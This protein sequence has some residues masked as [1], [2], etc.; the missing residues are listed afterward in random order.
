MSGKS[1]IIISP[2]GSFS[3]ESEMINQLFDA[4]VYRYHIHKIEATEQSIAEILE[5]VEPKYLSRITLHSHFHLVLAYGVGGIH[6]SLAHR[7]SLGNDY[8]SKVNLY[9]SF[10]VKVSADLGQE[11]CYPAD[12]AISTEPPATREKNNTIYV[13]KMDIVVKQ[14]E[15]SAL[16]LDVI[17][18][19][20]SIKTVIEYLSNPE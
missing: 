19:T 13:T 17:L 10:G 14:S 7:N 20:Y 18:K 16:L 1:T 5:G 11:D 3:N 12:Y 8:M 2:S 15:H 6:Y 9:Q 4:G